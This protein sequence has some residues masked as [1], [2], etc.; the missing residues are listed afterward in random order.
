[1]IF[2]STVNPEFWLSR[3]LALVQIEMPNSGWQSTDGYWLAIRLLLCH[4]GSTNRIKKTWLLC[5]PQL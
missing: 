3:R 5:N 1:M 4:R 2:L